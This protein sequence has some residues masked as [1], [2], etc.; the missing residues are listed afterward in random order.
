MSSLNG[1]LR[2][3]LARFAKNT[4]IPLFSILTLILSHSLHAANGIDDVGRA[5]YDLD[6]NGLIEINDLADLDEIRNNLDGKTLYGASLGCPNAED[7]TVNGGCIGFELTTDLDFDTN[8]NGQMDA[9]DD[10]WN[11]NDSGIG[12]GWLPVGTLNFIDAS[13]SFSTVFNGNGYVINNLTIN[14]PATSHVGLF[15]S[16]QSAKIYNLGINTSAAGI[17][18]RNYVAALAGSASS[19]NQISS[20]IIAANVTGDDYIAG[21]AGSVSNSN[22]VEHVAISGRI[23]GD[24]YVAG[25]VG[26]SYTRSAVSASTFDS[27]ISTAAVSGTSRVGGLIGSSNTSNSIQNSYWAT[28]ISGQTSSAYSSETNSYVGLELTT[29]Q[30][31]IS[32]NSDSTT[33]CVSADGSDEGLNAAVVLFKDWDNSIWDFGIEPNTN[34]QLPGLIFG[35]RILRDGDGDGVLDDYDVW[36]L[37]RAAAKDNDNDGYPDAWSLN[38]DDACIENSGLN[39]DKFPQLSGAW[40]D[41]DND[42]LVDEVNASCSE[43]CDVAAELLDA[44]IGDYDN[45]GI[46]D[47]VDS[48]EDNDGIN[49]IDADHDGLIDIDSLEKLNAI[50]FQPKGVGLQQAA[51]SELVVSGCPFVA[52]RGKYSR[53]CSGYE[54]TQDLN[55]DTNSNGRID[56]LD[57][58]WNENSVG[59][60][61]GWVPIPNFSA[62]FNGNGFMIQN[63]HVTPTNGARGGL[64]ADVNF[65]RIENLALTGRLTEVILSRYTGTLVGRLGN[66]VISKVFVASNAR[67]REQIGGIVGAIDGGGLVVNSFSSG[68]I[69]AAE[70][71]GGI[72]FISAAGGG[73]IRN[74]YSLTKVL[75]EGYGGGL[76]AGANYNYVAYNSYWA[77][78][79]TTQA[80]SARSSEVDSYVG[81]NLAQMQCATAANADASSGCVSVDGSGEDLNAPM[82]LF[83]DWD[84]AVWDFGNNQQAPGLKIGG[85]VYRDNDGDGIL[86]QNDAFLNNPAASLDADNDGYPDSWGLGC[87]SQ[88]VTASGLQ[89]DKFPAHAAVWQDQD[90][91]GRPDKVNPDCNVDC[92]LAGLVLDTDDAV[93]DSDGDGIS[94]ELDDDDNDDGQ[95][96]IDADSDGLVDIDSLAKLNAIRYQLSGAGLQLAE[97]AELNMSG[98]PYIIY[99]GVYQQ[100]CSGFELVQDLDFDTNADGVISQDDE[101]SNFSSDGKLEG[102]QPIGGHSN[103]FTS[104]LNGNNFHIKNLYIQRANEIEVGLFSRLSGAKVSNLNFSGSLARI[105]G[106]DDV[107]SLAGSILDKT[108]VRNVTNYSKVS[109]STNV[110]GLVGSIYSASE[111]DLGVNHGS[112]VANGRYL[113]GISGYISEGEIR[114]SYNTAVISGNDRVGGIVGYFRHSLIQGVFN[115]G[116]IQGQEKVGGLSGYSYGYNSYLSAGFNTGNVS[117]TQEVGGLVGS[118]YDTG[119]IETSYSTGRVT[120]DID[121]GGAIGKYSG[122]SYYSVVNTY[123]AEDASGQ[124]ASAGEEGRLTYLGLPLETL[125]CAVMANTT[126]ANSSCVS[127]DGSIEGLD[128]ALTLYKN[129]QL[130]TYPAENGQETVFWHFGDSNQLPGLSIDGTV[131]FDS[132]GD[133]VLDDQ[134][135]YPRLSIAG[136][137]DT[138]KNGIPNDCDAACIEIGMI[139]DTDDDNDGVID[140]NDFYPLISLAGAI[141]V[142]GDGIPNDCDA[143][144]IALGMVADT[145]NDNDGVIDENDFYPLISLAGATDTDGDG[146]PNDCDTACLELGMVADTD[147]D[148]DGVLDANDFYPLISLAGATDTDGDGIPND[149]DAACTDLGVVADTDDDNDGVIDENDF[150]PLISLA[151]ATDTD[152]DGIPNDCDEVCIGLEMVADTDDDNDDVL[153]EN[154][155][156][157]LISLSGATDT[158]GDGIPNDCDTACTELGM[159]AD[160]DDDNDGVID[161]N[162]FYPL[163]SLAGATDTDGDGIPN[164]CDEV[165]IELGMVAD[166]DDDNDGVIDVNDFYPLISLAGA[167]DTDGDGIPNDCDTACI[168]LGMVADTD[169]DNDG[170]SDADD[171]YPL[172]A[173]GELADFDNDGRPDICDQ[174]CLDLG[175]LADADN[176]NDG[177]ENDADAFEFNAAASLDADNDKLADEWNDGCLAQCQA[178]S[179]LTLDAY[180]NDTDNDGVTDD[181]DNDPDSDNG[182]PELLT[183]APTMYT[184]VNTDDGSAFAASADQVDAMFAALSAI[185][186]VD[187]S[188]ELIFKAYLNDTELVRDDDGQATLPSGL[189]V[190]RWVAVDTSGN[191]SEPLEQSVYVYPQVRFVT[192]EA[193]IGEASTAEIMV[194][195]SGDSPEYPV[196]VDVLINAEASSVDQADVGAEFDI[197]SVHTLTIEAG[198]DE[199]LLN[200]QVSLFIPI[201]EDDLSEDDELLVIDLV[202]VTEV[203]EGFDVFIIDEAQ[204][205]HTLTVTY[206]NLAPTVQLLIQQGG[207]EVGNVKQDGGDVTITAL[208]TDGNG[209]DTHTLAWDLNALNLNAPLGQELQF[210][211]TGLSAGDYALSLI[212]TDSG[213]N[214]EPVTASISIVVVE[215]VVVTP[216]EEEAAPADESSD[217]SS[218]GSSGGGAMFWLLMLMSTMLVYSNRRCKQ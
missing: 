50:R 181:L 106:D 140:V 136:L 102:W 193:I 28:D 30:C 117:G 114:S 122:Q 129:W 143:V 24:T 201:I 118:V 85:R 22:D 67:G 203:F 206:Q 49:D 99:Q 128:E 153:D 156:Y 55:F 146:I 32:E 41:A 70:A 149:C 135:E 79:S 74:S 66:S 71:A 194:E 182:L 54:L 166:T 13:T 171:G 20:I 210:S 94:N 120:A 6:D 38:C 63:L 88:C 36:P 158:D 151:G 61:E 127:A 174:G 93:T 98:C 133:G 90:N 75:S 125:R 101:F 115:N 130:E 202:S 167:T 155:S 40:L 77:K 165:C 57:D 87:D 126:S 170:V 104:T 1:F 46:L 78:D 191:E 12:E 51:D 179:A 81:V 47:T 25:A 16:L 72:A 195:L 110:G 34:Q 56:H 178:D 190:I 35:E 103:P 157:P 29:L 86:D 159:V 169:D 52:H 218:G 139:A 44:S 168:E 214:P 68:L 199:Q 8:G 33:G 111:I 95:I 173:I 59:V 150:Y 198:D 175:M 177:I 211:P 113:G 216:V 2:R 31:A 9:G 217:T 89:L 11:E 23:S 121:Y 186:V 180:T 76:Y 91:D 112:M 15:G 192:S 131:F 142:D 215:A 80:S 39:L 147:D 60:S 137:L 162:D 100:R 134:D 107:G 58:F 197:S 185:D 212:V 189:Q 205:T 188:A 73:A 42:G 207:V 21:L 183:V 62:I 119:T 196:M 97:D 145:D 18:G 4:S 123:W 176:D 213:I 148:N 138:D 96:D 7:G 132:D 53:R 172:I 109:G 116:D 69:Q 48:D 200:R 144:C 161:E 64:F 5:D 108:Q 83:R 92:S 19:G 204:Q 184:P 26:Y 187:D 10:Y 141:D 37:N 164:D 43:D 160:T 124:L 65:A 105:L 14:R 3:N 154:D 82:V 208:I 152:G 209:T 17:V 27:L 163:I 45:D 84:P